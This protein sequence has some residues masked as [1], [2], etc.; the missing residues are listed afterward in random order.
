MGFVRPDAH[1]VFISY[2]QVAEPDWVRAFRQKLQEHLDRELHQAGA[3]SIFWDRQEL[4]GDSPLSAEITQALSNAATLVIVLSGAYLDR[5]W[6]RKKRET[7][8]NLAGTSSGRAFIVLLENVPQEQRPPEIQAMEVLGFPFCEQHPESDNPTVTRPLPVTGTTFDARIREL[9]GRIASRLRSF[10]KDRVSAAP[11]Q[12][13]GRS[14]LGGAKVFLADGV[15][16]HP[17]LKDLE[18]D[19]I[20]VRTWLADHGVTV[21][22]ERAGSLFEAFYQ[23]RDECQATVEGL[24]KDAAIF[25][26]LLGR[27]GDD[28]GYESWLC[29]RAKAAGKVL[30]KDLLLW[31]AKSLTLESVKGEQHRELVFGEQVEC[32]DLNVEFLPHLKE[33]I[34]A[35]ERARE[36]ARRA[37]A[38][39][40]GVPAPSGGDVPKGRVLVDAAAEDC[41]LVEKLRKQLREK[42]LE[43]EPAQ[44]EQDFAEMAGEFAG[45]AF[46]FGACS[47]DSG[48]SASEG[49]APVPVEGGNT[50]AAAGRRVSRRIPAGTPGNQRHGRDH[51]WR[52]RVAGSIHPE[53]SGG[54][55]MSSATSIGRAPYPGLRPFQ[56]EDAE[57]FFGRETQINEMLTRI[58]NQPDF[59][60]LAVIGA[61]GSGKSSLVRAGLLPALAQGFLLGLRP[62][63]HS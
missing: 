30:G 12:S 5:P 31:R 32:S 7:F 39:L 42:G 50:K 29:E 8:F 19:R 28:D 24:I 48:Q 59:R 60:F 58:E 57:L 45:I 15:A 25:V 13:A 1:D 35:A 34:E 17:L 21:L 16:G 18:A 54:G 6:C 4:A 40:S 55:D 41:E 2:A 9:A 26:Q 43:Y 56:L 53:D 23:N 49:H 10:E 47:E 33:L 20:T 62:S 63:G 3:A 14:R 37:N 52:S 51:R 61:S 27:K 11:S 22:P 36:A 44:D 46:T 38:S